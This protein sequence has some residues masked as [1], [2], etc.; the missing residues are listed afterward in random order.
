LS[1]VRIA[2]QEE[3][4]SARFDQHLR[5]IARGFEFGGTGEQ[6]CFKFLGVLDRVAEG[7]RSQRVEVASGSVHHDEALL[8]EQ[9]SHQPGE[10][11]AKGQRYVVRGMRVAIAEQI[12]DGR[13]AKQF[14]RMI[15]QGVDVAIE[16]DV[17]DGRGM[18][19]RL[20]A[21]AQ[22]FDRC[23]A[24][25]RDLVDL[26]EVVV[27]G[28]EP[29]DGDVFDAGRG[30]RLFGA[31]YGGGGLEQGEQRASEQSDLLAGDDGASTSAKFGDVGERCRSGAKAK[32]LAF[33][34][35]GQGGR[36]R[37]GNVRPHPSVTQWLRAKPPAQWRV[38]PAL[39]HR[40]EITKQL[41]RVRQRRDGITLSAH[42]NPLAGT[43]IIGP[44]LRPFAQHN[45]PIDWNMP[46]IGCAI[47]RPDAG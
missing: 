16:S 39:A 34:R 8:G 42:Q 10:R 21:E 20:R 19:R 43:H 44:N 46:P 1:G 27:L 26:F 41:R 18:V 2:D 37:A 22:R 30:R 33:Q 11:A 17:S 28:G 3:Q 15:E 5:V 38:G 24:E 36:V 25:Q 6:C 45:S 47:C 31:S 12:A 4:R 23:F 7:G 35:I 32:A 14:A 29:E 40:E 13:V 9:A